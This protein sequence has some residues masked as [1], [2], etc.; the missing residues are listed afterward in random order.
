[1]TASRHAA[2]VDRRTLLAASA[3]ALASG[4]VTQRASAAFAAA[5]FA[6]ALGLVTYNWGKQWD[7]PALLAHC[8]AAEFGGVELRSTHKHGVEPSLSKNERR[9]VAKR[10]LDSPVE[11]VGLGSACEFHSPD[12]K[13]VRKNIDE[14]KAFVQLCHDVGGTG[15]KV[16]PNGIPQDVPLEKTL[17]QIGAALR[18]TAEFGAGYGVKIRLEVHGRRSQEIPLIKQMMDHADHPNAVVCWNCNPTDLTGKGLRH[19]YQLVQDKIEIFHIHDLR[20]D[21]Y[22]WNEL[23][24]LMKASKFQGWTL[25]EE[26]RTPSDILA[27]MKANRQVWRRL[28]ETTR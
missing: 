13:V 28:V 18:E 20:K 7:L 5:E 15:V 12:P 14:T 17:A 25:I 4:G 22:P 2:S 23:F 10:F 26:G 9:E 8:E 3:A 24:A 27:A 11:L 19:N 21:N 16:R 1:M 6:P